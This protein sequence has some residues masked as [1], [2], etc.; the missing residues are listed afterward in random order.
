MTQPEPEE[1]KS[2]RTP[3]SALETAAAML[4]RRAHTCLELRRKL[5]KKNKFPPFEIEKA[6]RELIRMGFLSD[7]RYAQD[8]VRILRGRGYGPLRIRSRLLTKGISRDLL[9]EVMA[10]AAENEDAAGGVDDVSRAVFLLRRAETRFAREED[11]RK[12]RMRMLRFLAGRGFPASDAYA[13]LEQWDRE[14]D[15]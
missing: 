10:D 2:A 7:L 1:K 14:P 12:R 9:D 5:Y 4:G 3:K 8:A 6:V 13:A 11:P 15:A